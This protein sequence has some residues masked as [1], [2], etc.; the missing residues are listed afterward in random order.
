MRTLVDVNEIVRPMTERKRYVDLNYSF[1]SV[2]YLTRVTRKRETGMRA[3][4]DEKASLW[5]ENSLA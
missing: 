3:S 2:S 1:T 4:L 5:R